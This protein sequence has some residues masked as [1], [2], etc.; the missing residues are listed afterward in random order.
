MAVFIHS[1]VSIWRCLRKSEWFRRQVRDIHCTSERKV[2]PIVTLEC[3]HFKWWL[4]TVAQFTRLQNQSDEYRLYEEILKSP[5]FDSHLQP[6]TGWRNNEASEYH[7]DQPSALPLR[8]SKL[9]LLLPSSRG[10]F[11]IKSWATKRGCSFRISSHFKEHFILFPGIKIRCCGKESQ[12]IFCILFPLFF[13]LVLY[14]S[15]YN[16][17][18]MDLTMSWMSLKNSTL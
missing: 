3:D 10:Y 6:D 15:F 18:E 9:N 2:Q 14:H 4:Y 11:G 5:R 13:A 1:P 16:Y 17:L 12:L 7:S 8:G